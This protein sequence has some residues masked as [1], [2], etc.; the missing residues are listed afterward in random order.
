[1]NL[2]DLDRLRHAGDVEPLPIE[3]PV[4]FAHDFDPTPWPNDC[5]PASM[6]DAANAIA[7]YVKAP[8]ALASMAI[9]ASVGHLAQRMANARHPAVTEP[10]PCSL[11]ILSI[12]NS[13]DR[14]SA[15]YNLAARPLLTS[16][17]EARQR[18]QALKDKIE[19]ELVNAKSGARGSLREELPRDPRTIYTEATLEK[20]IRDFIQGSR[21][22]MSWSTDEGAQFFAG[23][24]MK[25]DT[26]ASALGA[27]TR[28]FD[29]RGV[30]RD[31]VSQES[32]S[33]VRFNIRFSLFLSAQPAAVMSSLHD[34]LLQGQ[35]FLPRFL[36]SAPSSLAGTRLLSAEDLT[37]RADSDPRLCRYWSTL[38]RMNQA[39]EQLDNYGGLILPMA[40]WEPDALEMW[41][42]HYN[43]TER[44]L[45]SL[46]GDLRDNLQAFGGRA[47]ELVARVATVFSVWRY[48][49]YGTDNL[50]VSEADITKACLLIDYSLSEWQ[51]ISANVSLSETESDARGLLNFLQ[52]DTARWQTF[53]KTE[54]A[55]KGWRPLRNEKDRRSNA[56]D[57]LVK[58]HW[59]T[60]DGAQFRLAPP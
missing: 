26:R 15:V 14:K 51:R 44:R 39:H 49:E 43:I 37:R 8:L 27:L 3:P 16:E 19:K 48:F 53:T 20:I 5:L 23:Y 1:M 11:F 9:L 57:E 4:P 35:G 10:I 42:E 32:G 36:L 13:A 29:G 58:R 18:H 59:L 38:T 52:R 40:E 6:L 60:F 30:E 50:R 7:E 41:R 2:N 33:G 56:L 34:P 21:P 54:L 45:D 28:L 31:R 17:S 24:S 46:D 22:A 12:A 47:G 55:T 25:A